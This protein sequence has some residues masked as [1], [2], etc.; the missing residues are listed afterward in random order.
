MLRT[1]SKWQVRTGFWLEIL[2]IF[3]LLLQIYL[4][5]PEAI[6]LDAW[7]V[8]ILVPRKYSTSLGLHIWDFDFGDFF[9]D[10]TAHRQR[11]GMY[12]GLCSFT[13]NVDL[14]GAV[15]LSWVWQPHAHI[16]DKTTM[17]IEHEVASWPPLSRK[18]ERAVY[19]IDDIS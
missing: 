4:G 6:T 12:W 15:L 17:L 11:I 19:G 2:S 16:K 8:L 13:I 5:S 1:L 9:C 18:T 3:I 14:E 10:S 7:W